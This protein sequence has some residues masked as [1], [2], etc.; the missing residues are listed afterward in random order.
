[1]A[2]AYKVELTVCSEFC[3]YPTDELQIV[4]G[5]ILNDWKSKETGPGLLAYNVKT[6]KKS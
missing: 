1:M 4:I 5:E 3:A 2:T 6:I